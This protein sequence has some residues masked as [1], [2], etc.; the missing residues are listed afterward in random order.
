MWALW[1][2]RTHNLTCYF[3]CTY[4]HTIYTHGRVHI[5]TYP[6]S[7]HSHTVRVCLHTWASSL[8]L[9][10]ECVML[11]HTHVFS[12]RVHLHTKHTW[13]LRLPLGLLIS[14]DSRLKSITANWQKGKAHGMESSGASMRAVSL[15]FYR[16]FSVHPPRV[17]GALPHRQTCKPTHGYSTFIQACPHMDMQAQVYLCTHVRVCTQAPKVFS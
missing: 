15:E 17:Q 7:S 1:I 3:I 9:I 12:L 6:L 2:P 8:G 16:I 11:S 13:T 5:H 10:F 14:Q 4:L